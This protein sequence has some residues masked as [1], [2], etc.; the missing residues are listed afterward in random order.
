MDRRRFARRLLKALRAH[1]PDGRLCI[2]APDSVFDLGLSAACLGVPIAA[3]NDVD[4]T[5]IWR[6]GQRL[7]IAC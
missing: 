4:R 3:V 5:L 6:T 2:L 1:Y 7:S